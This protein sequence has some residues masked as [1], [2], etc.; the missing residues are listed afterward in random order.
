MSLRPDFVV[1]GNVV[2]HDHPASD[3]IDLVLIDT[4]AN[5][6]ATTPSAG[7]LAFASDYNRFYSADGTTWHG[8]AIKLGTPSTGVDIGVFPFEDD[9]GYSSTDID[10]KTLHNISVG[11]YDTTRTWVREGS[12]KYNPTTLK[13][14]VYVNAA[15]RNVVTMTTDEENAIMLWTDDWDGYDYYGKNIIHGH[16][17]D[18]GVFASDHLIDGGLISDQL[19]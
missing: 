11:G 5:I 2:M 13:L 16:A 10:T 3:V 8:V 7:K 17:V 14:Q 1:D 6:L 9:Q 18:M 12:M 4:R 15:W 19:I